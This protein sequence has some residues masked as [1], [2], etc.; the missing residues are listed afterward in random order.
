M[1]EYSYLTS[2]NVMVYNWIQRIKG[3]ASQRVGL[4]KHSIQ[5]IKRESY[6]MNNNVINLPESHQIEIDDNGTLAIIGLVVD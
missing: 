2:G 6:T 3:S 4:R 5:Y 1:A